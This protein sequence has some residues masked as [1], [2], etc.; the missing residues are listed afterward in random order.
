MLLLIKKILSTKFLV[1]QHDSLLVF[2]EVIEHLSGKHDLKWM[3][4]F[5]R[6]L[7][8]I[9]RML[10]KKFF[11][12]QN[13]PPLDHELNLKEM[14]LNEIPNQTRHGLHLI[15][16]I[17]LLTENLFI[18]LNE[19]PRPIAIGCHLKYFQDNLG[20]IINFENQQRLQAPTNAMYRSVDYNHMYA[21]RHTTKHS[22]LLY[23]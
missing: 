6:I 7:P 3:M 18:L 8:E 11:W 13:C 4:H 19:A 14:F 17:F 21:Y 22:H 23:E 5:N 10:A 12:Y 16:L 2:I 1:L 15:L 20:F 9:H